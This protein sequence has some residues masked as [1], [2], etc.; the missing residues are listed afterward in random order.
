MSAAVMSARDLSTRL[1]RSLVNPTE[2]MPGGMFMREVTLGSRRIDGLYCG[3][4]SSK[5]KILRGYEIKVARSDWLNELEQPAKADRWEQNV[6]EWWIVA[7]NTE[8]VRPEEVPHGWGLLI[9]DPNPRTKYRMKVVLRAERHLER[10]PSWD[11]VHAIIQKADTTRMNA[12][13]QIRQDAYAAANA[14]V[15]ERVRQGIEVQSG[16][17]ELVR[18]RDHLR[19][20]VT[21]IET[22][23]GL[24]VTDWTWVGKQISVNDLAGS[25]RRFLAADMDAAH[26]LRNERRSLEEAGKAIRKA[27]SALE[28]ADLGKLDD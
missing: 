9:P 2:A 8:I 5:G 19:R 12:L 14:Q 25:F 7:P 28:A 22:A 23:L 17:R 18:E 3:F 1:E 11:A 4:M 16:N 26:A 6:H 20:L 21:E 15:E 27:L 13:H 10:T 24:K